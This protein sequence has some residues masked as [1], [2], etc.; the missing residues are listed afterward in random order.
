MAAS[1]CLTA[2]IAVAGVLVL[3]IFY[4]RKTNQIL[5][6]IALTIFFGGVLRLFQIQDN[7]QTVH[8][9][10]LIMA[11][12]GAVWLVSWLSNRSATRRRR[13]TGPAPGAKPPEGGG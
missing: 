7:S 11:G 8:T 5:L 12:M 13:P 1:K 3:L 10:G 9:V 2:L 6:V 4:R